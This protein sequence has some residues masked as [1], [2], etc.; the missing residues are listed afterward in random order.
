MNFGEGIKAEILSKPPKDFHC[1]RAFLAGFIRGS[2]EIFLDGKKLGL[3]FNVFSKE[4]ASLITSL[5]K[6]VFNCDVQ[7]IVASEDRLN[8]RDKFTVSVVGDDAVTILTSLDI[9]KKS[10]GDYVV[11]LKFYGELTEKECCLRSFIKG[12]FLAVGACVV[13]SDN[14]SDSGYHLE[15]QFSHYTP[16][17]ETEEILGKFGIDAK[18]MRRKELY[19]LYIKSGEGIKDFTAFL[20][21]PKSM[22]KLTGLMIDRELKNKTNRQKNCDLGNV[23]RQVEAAAKQIEAVNEVEKKRGLDFLGAELSATARARRENPED[24]LAELAERLGISK[25]CLNHRLRKIVEISER[26]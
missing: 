3:Q 1:K 2:G 21:A 8:K 24:T 14:A 23:S 5:L 10:D 22:L 20:P 13:P 15:M 19:V 11:N 17:S 4:A 7:E 25:S 9:L 6:V 16:A 12:L 26:I 18:V